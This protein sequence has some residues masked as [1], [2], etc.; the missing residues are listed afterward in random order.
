LCNSF[1]RCPPITLS[2]MSANKEI[3]AV[4]FNARVIPSVAYNHPEVAW[5][6]TDR[7]SNHMRTS[8]AQVLDITGLQPGS[9]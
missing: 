8:M 4:D 9:A 2:V 1:F 6:G 5:M 7:K 3:H